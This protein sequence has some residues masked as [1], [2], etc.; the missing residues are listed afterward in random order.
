MDPTGVGLGQV[1]NAERGSDVFARLSTYRYQAAPPDPRADPQRFIRLLAEQTGCRGA[2]E[3]DDDADTGG[4]Q[5]ESVYFS[6]W[7]TRC[8]RHVG[9]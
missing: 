7:E 3:L 5:T 4:S 9:R 6:L 1:K 8:H 2:W